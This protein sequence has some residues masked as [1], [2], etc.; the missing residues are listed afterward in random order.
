[1]FD[2]SSKSRP[3]WD[4]ITLSNHDAQR[5]T[6][7]WV[8]TTKVGQVE[9]SWKEPSAF[10]VNGIRASRRQKF[11]LSSSR[12]QNN[13]HLSCSQHSKHR[14]TSISAHHTFLC[15]IDLTCLPRHRT[16][17]HW[18]TRTNIRQSFFSRGGAY[19]GKRTDFVKDGRGRLGKHALP[20][21]GE[22]SL[23]ITVHR[24]TR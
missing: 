18:R 1:M 9:M 24:V 19:V 15:Q 11:V 6:L 3:T 20:L 14:T 22:G 23:I 2:P 5:C 21:C 16:P 12:R 10:H 4:H 8:K 13:I 7:G 17:Q